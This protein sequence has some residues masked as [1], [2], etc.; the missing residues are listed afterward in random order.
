M[1]PE[2]VADKNVDEES[3][4]PKANYCY[5]VIA[6]DRHDEIVE[7]QASLM[8]GM[9]KEICEQQRRLKG[10]NWQGSIGILND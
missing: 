2:A 5:K 4:K 3:T 9:A 10:A 8:V 6:Q 7:V 1:K